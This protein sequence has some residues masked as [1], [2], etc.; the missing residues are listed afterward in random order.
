MKNIVGLLP[1]R[2]ESSRLPGKALKDIEGMPAIIH[3]YKRASLS[4]ML[5]DVYICT[6][7]KDIIE[8]ASQY[9]CKVIETGNHR[10]GTERINEAVGQINADIVINIQGDEVL[11]NPQHIDSIAATMLDSS[12]DYCLGVT[13]FEKFNS[14][15]D[16][17]AVL[18][19]SG[20]MIFC[21]RSDIPNQSINDGELLKV[22]FIVGFTKASLKQFIEWPETPLERAEPNEFLR[23]IEHGYKIKTVKLDSAKI[24]LDTESD[25]KEIRELM[26]N[27]SIYPMYRS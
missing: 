8:V 16:F 25:L 13:P 19:L 21:S 6:D 24:S 22:V 9:G 1:V 3:A 27:D 11:V 7:S 4:K 23:I 2:L 18:D 17:K 5:Q 15:Q 12:P 10:N 14:P 20:N 26:K